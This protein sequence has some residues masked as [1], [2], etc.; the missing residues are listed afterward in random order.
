M[1]LIGLDLDALYILADDFFK[2]FEPIWRKHLLERAGRRRIRQTEVS[3]SEIMTILI[4]FQIS[5]FR[6]FKAFYLALCQ[7]HRSE[8]PTLPSY[9]RFVELMPRA[10]VPL[11]AFMLALRGPCTGTSFVD[12]TVLRVCN[13]KRASRNK[14][15]AGLAA[16]AKSTM[17]W[18]FGFKLHLVSNERGALLGFRLTR[19][20]VDDRTPIK[21]GFF[22][23][24]FGRVFA[25][26]GY[27]SRELFV[28]LWDKGVKLVTGVR[29]NMGNA[30]L[31]LEEKILLRKRSICETIN[32]W[33]KN[34]CHIEHSRHRSP[35]NFVVHLV[36]GL[37]AYSLQPKKPSVRFAQ[38]IA[39]LPIAA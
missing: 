7:H 34:E 30:L 25:D 14:V 37:V 12:S 20:N 23:G 5:H 10:L 2:G 16:K 33:L 8:F 27:I 31:S 6:D 29:K 19:G 18:F 28:W 21:K 38:D 39:L 4:A 1:K 32:D 13:I 24:L 11:T 22:D 26:K 9:N 15:F 17:G 3:L 35:V 36:A